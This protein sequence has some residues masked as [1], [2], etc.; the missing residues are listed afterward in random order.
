MGRA[1]LFLGVLL[2]G[3]NV[4]SPAFRDQPATRV[5][6]DGSV[7]DVRLRGNLAEAIRVSSEYAPRFGPVRDRA[8]AAMTAASGCAV[9]S[10]RGDQA[11]SVGVLACDAPAA[12]PGGTTAPVG[13]SCID[14]GGLLNSGPGAPWPEFDCDPV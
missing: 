5:E 6:V 14:I 11:L 8:A 10:V 3:C 4:A 1:A 2:T 7:F 12:A 9:R 13:Y